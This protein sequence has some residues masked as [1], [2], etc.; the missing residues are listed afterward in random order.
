MII[1]YKYGF[2]YKEWLFVWSNKELFRY[3]IERDGRAY[4]LKLVT[5]DT[6]RSS[7]ENY[8]RCARDWLPGKRVKAMTISINIDPIEIINDKDIP[9]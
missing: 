6:E 9:F 3:P 2:W 7:R 4:S 5:V 8:Y 1:K